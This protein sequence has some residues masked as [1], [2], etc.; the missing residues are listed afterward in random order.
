MTIEEL[1]SA[2]YKVIADYPRSLYKVGHIIHVSENLEGFVFLTKDILK[3]PHIFKKM[4]WWEDRDEK[5]MPK[6]LKYI[7]SD[8]IFKPYHINLEFGL[9]YETKQDYINDNKDALDITIPATK[10]EYDKFIKQNKNGK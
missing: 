9:Y 7:N 6:Y 8:I 3:Y 2:R 1:T 4:E 10:K 5:N